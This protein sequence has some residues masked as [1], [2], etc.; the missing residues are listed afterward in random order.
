MVQFTTAVDPSNEDPKKPLATAIDRLLS[1]FD[2]FF[3]GL[4]INLHERPHRTSVGP[5]LAEDVAASVP[6]FLSR[7]ILAVQQA[8][9]LKLLL[10]VLSLSILQEH[11]FLKVHMGG[12]N[13]Q[14]DRFCCPC[15]SRDNLSAG[16]V[17]RAASSAGRHDHSS[18]RS[19]RRG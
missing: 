6:V 1:N 15:F 17:A 2:R 11:L 5:R 3:V 16:Y 13:D 12:N 8:A 18:P 7:H 4:P 10:R 14:V 9:V 19:M